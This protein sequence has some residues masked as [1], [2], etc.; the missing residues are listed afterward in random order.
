MMMERFGL[1]VT[2][3]GTGS[4]AEAARLAPTFAEFI[5]VAIDRMPAGRTRDHC[6]TYW[7]KIIAQPGWV[8]GDSTNPPPPNGRCCVNRSAPAG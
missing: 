3:L 5:P 4:L 8:N 1:T 2:D 6:C 7:N